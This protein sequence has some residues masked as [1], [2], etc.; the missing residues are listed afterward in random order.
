LQIALRGIT[1]D[2]RPDTD[3]VLLTAG[4][5][6]DWD[7]VV[8]YCVSRDLAGIECLSG[9]PGLIGGTP[10]QNVGA[11]GQEVADTIVSVE[12]FD[13]KASVPVTLGRAD[14][15]FS[16]RTSIFNTTER[17]RFIVLGVTFALRRGG[18]PTVVYGDVANHF[19]GRRPTLQEVR[20]VVLSIR[21][22]KSMVIDE[23]DAN[24]RSAG[25]F[26]KNPIIP[27][28]KFE[29]INGGNGGAPSFDAGPGAVK[30]PA[31]WLIE[32]SG[33]GKGFEFGRV[34]ISS[35]HTLAL[36]NRGEAAAAEII[37]LKDKIQ[38]AVND[39]FGISLQPEPVFVGFRPSHVKGFSNGDLEV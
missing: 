12:C 1:L 7:K 25:S 16:Y 11:Y 8:E 20:D 6:E 30:I 27:L 39:K 29:E 3:E 31:A 9:I 13:R 10:I 36:I 33:F 23:T 2:E 19:A 17:D 18:E 21:R 38:A 34:G 28:K 5:G 14:C 37:A 24:S 15:G 22:S 26:F 4:A 32:K 35:K